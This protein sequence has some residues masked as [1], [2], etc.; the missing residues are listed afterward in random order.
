MPASTP[1]ACPFRLVES[2]CPARRCSLLQS[3]SPSPGTVTRTLC[4]S[5]VR[6]D[7]VALVGIVRN[8]TTHAGLDPASVFVKW[9]DLTLSARGVARSTETH[10]TRTT[11]A[12]VG[13][14]AAVFPPRQRF[15]RGRS[16]AAPR[17][18]QWPLTLSQAPARFDLT[19]DTTARLSKPSVELDPDSSGATLFPVSAGT[20]RFH[21]LV[22][23]VTGG[24]Y[25]TRALESSVGVPRVLMRAAP[26]PSIRLRAAR[27]RWRSYRLA[28]SR[29]VVWSTSRSAESRLIPSFS[30]R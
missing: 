6:N 21:V 28:T 30:P 5:T 11:F 17:P 27:K 13:T 25:P 29:N 24:P 20:A 7:D 18:A 15:C 14:S 22:R 2:K 16:V 4:G 23:D 9:V 26:S 8:A 12:T 19:L 3:E 10:A 1:F